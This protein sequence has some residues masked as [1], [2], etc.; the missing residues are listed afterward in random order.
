MVRTTL[1]PWLILTP[2]IGETGVGAL[3]FRVDPSAV[4]LL[5]AGAAVVGDVGDVDCLLQ[6]AASAITQTV[7][8][9]QC[10]RFIYRSL[11]HKLSNQY[12]FF[13]G[14]LED[15]TRQRQ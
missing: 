13:M 10:F 12:L 5:V 1:S 14:Q 4:A 6:A 9:T 8:A 11:P 3:T 7:V 15:D 2:L